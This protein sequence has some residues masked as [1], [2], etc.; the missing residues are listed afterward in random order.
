MVLASGFFI[1]SF[2]AGLPSISLISSFVRNLPIKA[3]SSLSLFFKF[4]SAM[5]NILFNSLMPSSFLLLAFPPPDKIPF[6]NS[7]SSL[8][9]C[10]FFKFT[11]AI[12]KALDNSS[13]SSFFFFLVFI[14]ASPKIAFSNLSS[15]VSLL[16]CFSFV[17]SMSSPPPPNILL[18]ESNWESMLLYIGISKS[19]SGLKF[20]SKLSKPESILSSPKAFII[21]SMF[22]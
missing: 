16:L 7:A 20:F 4:L 18:K 5:D 11:S 19:F 9:P 8:D 12:F 1:F 21:S 10:F 22:P 2:L 3:I 14:P 17:K 15:S 13:I 6:N